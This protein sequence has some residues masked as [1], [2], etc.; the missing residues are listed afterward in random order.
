[1]ERRTMNGISIITT[2][3]DDNHGGQT[4]DRFRYTFQYNIDILTKNDIDFEYI[5]IDWNP[6]DPSRYL[7]LNPTLSPFFSFPH[8][9]N[10]IIDRS[11]LINEGLVPEKFYE[12]FAKNVG[13]RRI[14][15]KYLMAINFDILI[16]PSLIDGIKEILS[17][18]EKI[19]KEYFYRCQFRR[20]YAFNNGTLLLQ[21]RYDLDDN[22]FSDKCICG[23]YSGDFLVLHESNDIGYNE[24]DNG[25]RSHLRQTGMD[26]EILWTLLGSGKKLKFV[27]GEYGHIDHSRPSDPKDCYREGIVYKNRE[28]WGFIKYPVTQISDNISIIHS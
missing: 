1:M 10:F 28:D 20:N 24:T 16:E 27:K 14:T 12:Y 13:M 11:V 19:T 3:R 18:D 21:D 2:N 15:K 17:E 23:L 6:L 26:G 5:I 8:I 22:N 9:K 4:I 7:Y 25:H